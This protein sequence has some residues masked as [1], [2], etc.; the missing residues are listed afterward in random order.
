M[1]D[2]SSGL[3]DD[4]KRRN[5]ELTELAEI[6]NFAELRLAAAVN[7]S[8]KEMGSCCCGQ[9]T[10][11]HTKLCGHHKMALPRDQQIHGGFNNKYVAKSNIFWMAFPA[12]WVLIKHPTVS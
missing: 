4:A 7:S 11:P 12:K 6:A 3:C 9:C 10:I 5:D 8:G 2:G 1:P